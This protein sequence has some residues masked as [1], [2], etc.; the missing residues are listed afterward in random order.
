MDI[1]N[2]A[3]KLLKQYYRGGYIDTSL[4]SYNDDVDFLIN[5]KCLKE[6]PCSYSTTHATLDT[7]VVITPCGKA[8]VETKRRMLLKHW[9]PYF[10][11]TAISLLSLYNA[12]LARLN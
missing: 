12:I 2:S 1:N 6:I 7:K 3:Y 4:P 11:T 9:I 8:V 10:I 5:K